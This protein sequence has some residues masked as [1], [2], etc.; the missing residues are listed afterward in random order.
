MR[1]DVFHRRRRH[2][3]STEKRA[4]TKMVDIVPGCNDEISKPLFMTF[5][6]VPSRRMHSLQVQ[7][8]SRCSFYFCHCIISFLNTIPI[9]IIS[10]TSH[11]GEQKKV[12]SKSDESF[13]FR[14]FFLLRYSYQTQKLN[15]LHSEIGGEGDCC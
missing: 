11:F 13:W 7:L 3:C 8:M 4:A 14:R 6:T 2:C 9:P 12:L 10:T 1:H 5:D 15:H